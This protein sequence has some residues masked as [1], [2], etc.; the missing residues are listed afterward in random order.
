MEVHVT[1]NESFRTL[2]APAT[3]ICLLAGKMR[4]IGFKIEDNLSSLSK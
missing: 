3:K 4:L 1:L 2:S